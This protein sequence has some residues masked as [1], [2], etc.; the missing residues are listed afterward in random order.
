VHYGSDWGQL[1]VWADLKWC[2]TQE[3]SEMRNVVILMLVVLFG[4]SASGLAAPVTTSNVFDP[5]TMGMAKDARI[6]GAPA[7]D[8]CSLECPVGALLEGEPDCYDGYVDS[9]NGGCNSNPY[10]F[11]VLDPAGGTITLCGTSGVF[12]NY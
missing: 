9:Y 11:S 1:K 4:L 7:D 8:G 3:V 2:E 12:D 6:L 5:E 10:V